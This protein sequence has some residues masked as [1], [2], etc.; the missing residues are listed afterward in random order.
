MKLLVDMNLT[1][2]WVGWLQTN[3]VEAMHWSNV[4]AHDAPD[5]EVMAHA[6]AHHMVVMTH[7][8]DFG[9]ILA[10]SGAAH[11]SVLQLRD[12]N[13]TP[14]VVGAAVLSALQ[15]LARDLEVGA[16]VSLDARRARLRLLPLT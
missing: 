8:M 1:P 13:P 16:L 10:A 12:P 4:G 9:A 14:E 3:G 6:A 7:D 5:A 11:P 15:Q 2:R